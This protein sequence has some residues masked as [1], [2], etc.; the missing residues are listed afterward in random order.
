[1][2][3]SKSLKHCDETTVKRQQQPKE[4]IENIVDI[5]ICV[6]DVIVVDNSDVKPRKLND[7]LEEEKV[8][9]HKVFGI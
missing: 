7:L 3:N 6:S 5:L 4:H 8:V 1:M 9:V 2:T